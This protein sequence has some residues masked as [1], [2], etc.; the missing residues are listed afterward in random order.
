MHPPPVTPRRSFGAGLALLGLILI[1]T[2]IPFYLAQPP[3]SR[4]AS[5]PAT[6]FSAERAMRLSREFAVE[7]R[8][9]GTAA[10]ERAR[11]YLVRQLRAL[12]VEV[13]V[14]EAL[15]V[16]DRTANTVQNVLGRIPGT[17]N[18]RSF[19]MTAHYDSVHGGP[20]AADDG[21]GVIAMIET[22]RA[23]K[24]GP[25]LRNDV[26]LAFTGDE[27][28]GQ[29]GIQAFTEHAWAQNAGI[30]LG[31]EARG[32]RGP[33]NMF[34]TS[35]GNAWLIRELVR[36]GVPAR[37]N[38]LMYELHH[39]TPNATDF[40]LIKGSRYPGYNVAFVGGLG[41]YHT[42][43]DNPANLSPASIQHQ[44]EYALALAR[45]FGNFS[46]QEFQ[47]KAATGGDAVYFNTLGSHLAWYPAAWS[48][49]IAALAAGLY[50]AALGLGF[51]RRRLCGKGLLLGAAAFL[52]AVL[53][54]V[55][56]VGL[57]AWIA[58]KQHGVY[59]IY[60]DLTYV[61]AFL[62][63]T[64]VVS[65]SVYVLFGAKARPLDLLAGSLVWSLIALILLEWKVPMGSYMIAWPL[66]FAS[67]GLMAWF[68]LPPREP[69]P[70]APRLPAPWESPLPLAML[71]ASALPG[72]L[73]VGPGVQS[74][75]YMGTSI[76]GV[77]YMPFVVLLVSL[78]APQ[79]IFIMRALA[80]IGHA[81]VQRCWFPAL[82]GAASLIVYLVGLGTNGFSAV[83]PKM[84]GVSYEL[85]LDA[86]QAFWISNDRQLDEWTSQFFP[87]DTAKPDPG[88]PG[89]RWRAPAPVAPIQGPQLD[90]IADRMVAGAR[91]LKL[92]LTSPRKVP[93][94]SLRVAP[95]TEVLS[96]AVN[97]S[98]V[99]GGKDWSVQFGVLPR[100][101]VI[102]LSLTVI[103]AGPLVMAVE[104]KTFDLR[105]APPFRPR[106]SYMIPRPN[107][108]DWFESSR[109]PSDCTYVT[110][111]FQFPAPPEAISQTQSLQH[112]QEVT[113]Q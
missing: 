50:L 105:A 103:P 86:N 59:M 48:R 15:V 11:D 110:R 5:A 41:Y 96:A 107:T 97:G 36:S 106:P 79:I 8:P 35:P 26:I 91:E 10:L 95:P 93:E 85:D 101:G 55:A 51:W 75:L 64:F 104:E 89:P 112:T 44:G 24:A 74:A 20:G 69:D 19:V 23:L 81:P 83:K 46:A 108:I 38:S 88:K 54:S 113:V 42:A 56:V 29:R 82:V 21:A 62:G 71:M 37:A 25:P 2:L 53:L 22:A 14:Q 39:R 13:E 6:E 27:E 12:G 28:R 68:Q 94:A 47:T 60:N 52:L 57:L 102:E 72:F 31:F 111:T 84:N 100:S 43:N 32:V 34:E 61:L 7:P 92:R 78:L 3:R 1:L 73:M 58:Y 98:A 30:V 77:V 9:A 76:L 90:V 33:A 49:Q 66:L 99:E 40:G 18:A 63:V 67:A 45:H 16:R 109:L 17:A 4:P 80:G 87:L 70:G 65:A